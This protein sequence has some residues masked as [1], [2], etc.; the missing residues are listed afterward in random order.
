MSKKVIL[1]LFLIFV[2]CHFGYG[3][4]SIKGKVIDSENGSGLPYVTITSIRSNNTFTTNALGEFEIKEAGTYKFSS[5]GYQERTIE[6]EDSKYQV[7]QLFVKPSELN[8]VIVSA[9]QLS[10]K[11]KKA[12]ATISVLTEKEIERGN[13]FNIAPLLNRVPGVYQH[14]GV[15]NT[16][17]ITIR[18]IGSR[19]LFGTANIRAY[20]QDIPLT[21]G[22]GETTIEDFELTSVSRFEIIKGAASS[23][24]GAGLG[25]TIHLIPQKAYLNET[26]VKNEISFGSFGLLKDV[27]NVNHGSSKYSLKAIYSNT[28]SDGFRDNNEYDRQTLTVNYNHYL[29]ENDELSFIGSYVD[30][31]AFIPSSLDEE[32][33]RNNPTAAAFTWGRAQGFE[34][35]KRGIFGLSWNHKYSNRLKHATSI[36][37]SFRN[38]YEARPFNILDENL[39]ALGVRSRLVGNTEFFGKKLDWTAGGELFRDR[40]ESGTFENLFEDFPI[41]TGSVEGERLSDFNEIRYYYNLFVETNYKFTDNTTF[42]AGLNFNRTSYD[43]RDR[44]TVSADN[45][46]QSGTFDFDGILSPKFGLSHVFS[47]DISIYSSVSHGFSPLTI[48]ETLLPDGQINTDLEPETGWNFELGTRGLLFNERLQFNLALYRLD[49]RNL[50]VS[51]R[52]AEDQ[53]IGINAGRTRHDGLEIDLTYQWLKSTP[54]KLSSYL[55]YSLNNF[56]FREFIDGDNDFSGNDLTGVPSGVF[57]TGIDFNTS[58]GL[59]GSINFQYV[60]RIPIT[61]SNSLFSDTYTLTNIKLGYNILV[62]KKLNFN[63]FLGIDNLFDETY[64][65][66][67]LINARGFGG[68]APRFFY[69]GNP[70][71]Y[72]SGLSANYTF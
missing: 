14:N 72:Y 25:G 30:L 60:G 50:L 37:T 57:N 42:T 16:N 36:F 49:V 40:L 44:F 3:Q 22:N 47:N 8:E 43:L 38:S 17:R 21:S 45:P 59:Y 29:G 52:T 5:A 56:T 48:A 58:F 61:D 28:H 11:L 6:I 9:N 55:T 27:V 2:A 32:T 15:L 63:A 65:S 34:N 23:I 69:P 68:N 24:Y 13:N 54:L 51:R 53:F 41:G 46:D 1:S 39:F 66:Q 26:S 71:N 62:F 7:I 70:I 33:F 31:M 20:F 67:I 35:T 4:T 12:V 64:A 19:N 10:K 18:G